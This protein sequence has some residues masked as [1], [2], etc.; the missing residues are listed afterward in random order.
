MPLPLLVV[1]GLKIAAGM[2]VSKIVRN[3]TD[4]STAGRIAGTV[5]SICVGGIP[6]DGGFADSL[7]AIKPPVG[8][9]DGF[10]FGSA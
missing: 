4:N 2:A 7:A 10:P 5:A 9:G 3:V 6:I 8:P 1:L